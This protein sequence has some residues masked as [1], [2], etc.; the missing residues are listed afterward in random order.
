MFIRDI[1]NCE[2]F[3]TMDET[4]LC[5]ILHPDREEENL[6]IN[7]SIAHAILKP[8]ESSLVHKLKT[9]VEIYYI[10]KG[11]GIMHV[12]GET[13]EIHPEQVIYIPANSNQYIENTG[14]EE[15]K[16]LC[17]VYPMWKEDDEEIVK[18]P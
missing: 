15:L 14:N 13:E 2:Y 5:E 3:R 9:S 12:D 4:L 10:L 1:K 11:K 18:T 17:I 8:N 7:L 6:K 16:F